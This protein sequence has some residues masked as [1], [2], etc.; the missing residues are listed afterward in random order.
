MAQFKNPGLRLCFTLLFC[1]WLFTCSAQDRDDGDTLRIAFYNVEN[2]FYPK[3]DSLKNDEAFT[4]DGDR[5]W[6]WYRYREKYHRVAKAILSIGQWEAPAVIGLAEVENRRT[7]ED[8][9]ESATLRKTPYQI[10][11]FE[12]PDRRGIDVGALFRKDRLNLL[13]A[14]PVTVSMPEKPDFTTRDLLYLKFLLP[15]TSDTLHLF[16]CHWPSR[17]G[18]KAQSE[19]KRI[20]AAKTLRNQVDSIYRSQA[21]A[22]CLI[23]GDFNDEWHNISLRDSLRALPE[24]PQNGKASDQRIYNLMAAAD[25]Q[26]GSHRYQGEWA[27]L[28]QIIASGNLLNQNFPWQIQ[29]KRAKILRHPFLLEK[30]Q[31]YPGEKP[32]RS[33]IG[34]RYN[35]GFSDHLPVFVDLHPTPG[36]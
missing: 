21:Q 29:E 18:G 24:I 25:P 14:M 3:N 33:F 13:H 36:K 8:L 22:A 15:A 27:Y 32:F 9:T 30:D 11:H 26:R 31:R 20:A 2:L 7:M 5:N 12:S 35:G 1:G 28:D 6:S 17:Y 4:P 10:V 16:Y 34:F 19:P 23:M